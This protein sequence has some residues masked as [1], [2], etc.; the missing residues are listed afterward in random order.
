MD[1][2]IASSHTVRVLDEEGRV[3]CPRRCEATV[4]SLG[5]IEAA[6]LAGPPAGTVLEVVMEPTGPAWLPVAVFFSARGAPCV[7][8][9]QRQ[10]R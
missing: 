9:V 5:R 6:A 4:D 8:G 10:G 2:G 3:V 7:P 1:L